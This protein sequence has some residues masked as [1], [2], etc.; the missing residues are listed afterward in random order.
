MSPDPNQQPTPDAPLPICVDLD[1]TLVRTDLLWESLVLWLRSRP[2]ELPLLFFW[3]LRGRV[4]LK[5]CLAERARP[6]PNALPYTDELRAH[7]RKKR[8][9]GHPLILATASLRPLAESVA[10]HI[11]IFDDI[12]ATDPG[13][14]NMRSEAKRDALV[15]RYGPRGYAY[16]GNST[17]DLPVWEQSAYAIVVNAPASL[18][19]RASSLAEVRHTLGTPAAFWKVL[20]KAVRVHQWV[21][22]LLL[23]LPLLGAHRFTDTS[24]LGRTL[25]AILSFSFCASAVYLVNDLS[26]LESDRAH[27]TKRRR[28]LASG[29]LSIQA[30]L[31]LAFVL[32]GF[33]AALGVLL[34]RVLPPPPETGW[35]FISVLLTYLVLTTSYSVVLKRVAILDVLVLASLYTIRIF[36]G[37]QAT[38]IPIS[39]W[40][41]A[42][43]MFLFLSLAL[44]K[45]YSELHNLRLRDEQETPGRGYLSTDIELVAALGAASGY[46]S[47]LVLAL[48]IQSETVRSLYAQPTRIWAL[49]PAVLYWISRLWLIAHRG[50]MHEDPIVFAIKDRASYVLAAVLALVMMLAV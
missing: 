1:G 20:P 44:L 41:L 43:S 27:P 25:L 10:E 21:K 7:L 2:W 12:L 4:Y 22:N 5:A 23:F 9:E 36:A 15:E 18:A 34:D 45:R 37:S 16:A 30:G 39:Q 19:Q 48:Y 6:K 49:C 28:P 38:A 14:P 8:A 31:V 32:L 35:A 13:G 17:A 29:A 42:F 40:L 24:A 26:D 46:I 3:L 33:S 47:V 11:G 50:E